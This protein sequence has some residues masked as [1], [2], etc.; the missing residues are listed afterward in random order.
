M[1]AARLPYVPFTGFFAGGMKGTGLHNSFVRPFAGVA[2][3]E[4]INYITE[5]SRGLRRRSVG[6]YPFACVPAAYGRFA[7]ARNVANRCV[8]RDNKTNV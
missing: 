4:P 3:G 2:E 1:K 7:R 8:N 5:E 6:A